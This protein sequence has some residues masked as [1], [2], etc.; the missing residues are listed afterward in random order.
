MNMT[1]GGDFLL[2][3][4]SDRR[5]L[6]P[7]HR[8]MMMRGNT[9]DKGGLLRMATNIKRNRERPDT[10]EVVSITEAVSVVEGSDW[11]VLEFLN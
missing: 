5:N 4:S 9:L 6:D 2:I 8:L 1:K 10:K 11:V 3:E 7:T